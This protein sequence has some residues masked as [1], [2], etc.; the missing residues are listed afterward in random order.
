MSDGLS[1]FSARVHRALE[2]ARL[3]GVSEQ[4]L[5]NGLYFIYDRL[6]QDLIAE[7]DFDETSDDS[8]D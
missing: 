1:N 3:A 7:E 6:T 4:D 8:G 5:I 2:I